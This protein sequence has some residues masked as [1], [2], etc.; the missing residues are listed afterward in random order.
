MAPEELPP[1]R[2]LVTTWWV[3]E[4]Y[5]GQTTATLRRVGEQ[6]QRSGRPVDLLTFSALQDSAE[7]TERLTRRGSL[8]EGVTVRT[9]FSDLRAWDAEGSLVERLRTLPA[10]APSPDTGV[11]TV[12]EEGSRWCLRTYDEHR[13]L[14]HSTMYRADGSPLAR[15]FPV[16][17]NGEKKRYQQFFDAGGSPTVLA[18][19]T[20]DVY[21]LWLDHLV[22]DGPAVIINE[23]KSTARFLSRYL[24]PR[25]TTIHVFHESHLADSTNPYKGD[26]YVAHR[27]IV[28]HLDRFDAVVFL[29]R[30][31]RQDV[32]ERFGDAPNLHSVPN[33]GPRV[34]PDVAEAQPRSLLA[35][36][37]PGPDRPERGVVVATL[38]PLKRIEHAVRAVALVQ[39]SGGRGPGFGLDVY[40]KDAGSQASIERAVE[41]TGS[42]D[43]V[44]LHGYAPGAAK[45]FAAA[46]FSLM[47]STTEGQSLVLLESMAA[48]CV[49]ISYDIRYGPDELLVDGETG[50]LVPA[51]DVSALAD[52]IR[53]F[54]DLPARRVRQLRENARERL[55][56]FSDAEVYRRWVEVQRSAVEARARR[57]SLTSLEV[58]RF[59]VTTEAGRFLLDG[60]AALTWD[61]DGWTAPGT[62]PAPTASWLLVGRDAGRPWRKPLA[63]EARTT[64]DGA[65]LRMSGALDPLAVT[66]GERLCDVYVEVSAGS[67]VR[68]VRLNGAV[69]ATAGT[70]ELYATGYGNVSLR[71]R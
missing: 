35:R 8:P 15:D 45:H 43:L 50:F 34:Q 46:S 56:A 21:Y 3:P 13:E 48:G 12:E 25:A 61:T 39:R 67:S 23:S 70:S 54:L 53:R 38:K 58:P 1:A 65:T 66:V 17:V 63:V 36:L 55:A 20:W 71:R 31:Q 42:A 10:T 52:T 41:E 28:P 62:P 29:T 64:P 27:R 57:L 32:A 44:T 40:G 26:L 30:K 47:T 51:G 68:R 18:G 16:E 22:G 60:E 4:Q 2:Q 14:V 33:A 37:R 5:A 69:S 59:T 6:V 19:S 7:I 11:P 24:N 9:L 49:P